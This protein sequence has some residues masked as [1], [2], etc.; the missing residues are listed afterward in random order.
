MEGLGSLAQGLAG[1]F[2]TGVRL[3]IEKNISR[4]Q[5]LNKERQ[6]TINE[7]KVRQEAEQQEYVRNAADSNTF[8]T[9]A[10]KMTPDQQTSYLSK[11]PQMPFYKGSPPG[12]QQFYS[13]IATGSAFDMKQYTQLTNSFLKSY[14][15]NDEN[16]MLQSFNAMT[17]VFGNSKN[18]GV[19]T[20][21]KEMGIM[22]GVVRPE[23]EESPTTLEK[24]LRRK[25]AAVPGSERESV[26][27]K[28]IAK[29][30]TPSRNITIN[31]GEIGKTTKQ[32]LE[33]KYFQVKSQ[34]DEWKLLKAALDE[35]YDELGALRDKGVNLFSVGTASKTFLSD[36]KRKFNIDISK[37]DAE[38]LK[39]YQEL[40]T[41]TNQLN[42]FMRSELFG[43]SLTKYEIEKYLPTAPQFDT[44]PISR[45][46]GTDSDI[47]YKQK[48]DVMLDTMERSTNRLEY[49][50]RNGTVL[51]DETGED[52]IF[53]DEKGKPLDLMDT[54]FDPKKPGGRLS[55]EGMARIFS[56]LSQEN[57]DISE[58][59]IAQL[60]K[61][62][63][64]N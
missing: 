5:Q 9:A 52:Y 43:K 2:E 49:V 62:N 27:N 32:K 18:E 22:L 39:K 30:V 48:L 59:E 15:E 3:G 45:F 53:L 33:Q 61:D 16:G 29:E 7:N 12:R 40:A 38:L 23:S 28:A 11:L 51:S 8:F 17:A 36:F 42:S 19:K 35:T 46:T 10:E 37:E 1:G 41:K 25:E 13:A 14:K 55:A 34:F 4:L 24:F 21:L 64:G 56:R 50:L 54:R 20:E 58:D 60:V 63:Y 6:L 47:A 44:G 57:P 26:Y 31:T